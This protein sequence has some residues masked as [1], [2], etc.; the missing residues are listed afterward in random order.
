[1][2]KGRKSMN[3]SR[4]V[5]TLS[6]MRACTHREGT[7]MGRVLLGSPDPPDV[8]R[9]GSHLINGEFRTCRY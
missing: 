5:L 3:D 4:S 6:L 8:W 9:R 2:S 1:M 7:F